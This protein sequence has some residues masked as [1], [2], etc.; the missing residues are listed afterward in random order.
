MIVLR[1]WWPSPSSSLRQIVNFPTAAISN[2]KGGIVG[3]DAGP[4]SRN[5]QTAGAAFIVPDPEK[6]AVDDQRPAVA[7]GRRSIPAVADLHIA[8]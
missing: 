3:R 8:R 6:S 2:I 4:A 7:D 5:G 1:Y